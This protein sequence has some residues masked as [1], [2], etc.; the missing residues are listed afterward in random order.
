MEPTLTEFLKIFSE[1]ACLANAKVQFFF[2]TAKTR[3]GKKNFC[4]DQNYKMAVY[5]MTAHTATILDPSRA[6]NGKIT[7]EKA[8]DLSVSYDVGGGSEMEELAS[9]Q[10]GLQYLRLTKENTIGA[11]VL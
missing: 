8:G 4:E 11:Q 9:T 1:F 10:Y 7:S 3:V 6:A 2:D 5:L